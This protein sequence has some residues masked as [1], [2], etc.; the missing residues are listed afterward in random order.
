M[1]QAHGA[2][3]FLV[4]A[5]EALE[6]PEAAAAFQ[7]LLQARAGEVAEGIMGQREKEAQAGDDQGGP[8][9]EV[10]E[11]RGPSYCDIAGSEIVRNGSS[12]TADLRPEPPRGLPCRGTILRH[13]GAAGRETRRANCKPALSYY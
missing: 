3:E 7:G 6:L 10:Q 2:G 1:Q 5:E 12:A 8:E 13:L 11:Q 9:P 4:V